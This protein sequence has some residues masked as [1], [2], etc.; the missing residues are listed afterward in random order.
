MKVNLKKKR[1][2]FTI[3][4]NKLAKDSRISLKAKGMCLVLVHFPD[5]WHFY[6][7]K[8]Q[9]FCTDKRTA[10]SNA[11]KELE[12]AGYL[13]REQ[14]REKGRFANKVWVFSD[15]GLSEDD[16]LGI[17]TECKK[18]DVGFPDFGKS[19]TTN[20][21]SYKYNNENKKK[22]T[23]KKDR[24]KKFY[25]YVNLLKQSGEQ[26]PN[27]QV[28]FENKTY[29]FQNVNGQLLLKDKESDIILS[30]VAAERLYQKMANSLEVKVIRG[31]R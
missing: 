10:I 19:P 23:Q 17:T 24:K 5:D 27:L 16:I 7:E 31:M 1:K 21:H 15:E 28:E 12:T 2:N 22:N 3:I 13:H 29:C 9:D 25:D 11:L 14:L 20:T 26:Y 30:K 4:S 18:T 8:L 6:E